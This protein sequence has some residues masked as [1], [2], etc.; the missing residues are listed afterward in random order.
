METQLEAAG[1]QLTPRQIEL[2]EAALL[3]SKAANTRATYASAMRTFSAWG[4]ANGQ[5]VLPSNPATVA[6]FLTELADQGRAMSTITVACSSIR[7]SHV[8]GNFRD[9]TGER[10]VVVVMAGL[11]RRL[12]TAPRRQARAF[13]VAELKR[14][15][16]SIDRNSTAGKRDAALILLAYGSAMRRSELVALKRDDVQ[17]S[18]EGV[19]INI[20]RSK[21]DQ[22]GRGATVGVST[23][24]HRS[25][26]VTRAL[27]AWLG[28]RGGSKSDPVFA[29]VSRTGTVLAGG[30][31]GQS[32][33]NILKHHAAASGVETQSLSAHSTRASHISVAVRAGVSLPDLMQT[34]R[35]KSMDTL[36][37]YVRVSA[38][39]DNNSGGSLGL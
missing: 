2:V 18:S 15:L 9:P 6:A 32:V 11:R 28:V 10:G 5:P 39:F 23:G 36:L 29:R 38:V 26:D 13:D 14:I 22:D 19:R 33:N 34:T 7:D 21:S 3:D 31:T 35:H 4:L 1:T 8:N 20:R 16:G 25:T 27:R 12:G 24:E 37:G 30:L 17:L